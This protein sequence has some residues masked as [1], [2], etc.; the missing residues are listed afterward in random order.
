MNKWTCE[1]IKRTILDKDSRKNFV[2]TL[3]R[4][5]GK[6]KDLKNKWLHA[7]QV[8]ATVAELEIIILAAVEN[9]VLLRQG[10]LFKAFYLFRAEL[11]YNLAKI[12]N[13][14]LKNELDEWKDD[15]AQI[16]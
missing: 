15:P 5:I 4:P 2:I 16:L 12:F 10:D 9:G 14:D 8:F 7:Y 11:V 1:N 13:D 3:I 6:E